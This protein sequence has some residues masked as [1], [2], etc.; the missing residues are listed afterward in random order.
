MTNNWTGIHCITC[1]GE[2][3][4]ADTKA[5]EEFIKEFK[6]LIE[7]EGYIMQQVFNW[8]ETRLFW[9]KMSKRTYTLRRKRRCPVTNQ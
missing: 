4:S 5:A 6:R 1:H 7:S 8:D 9:K 3:A 2:A